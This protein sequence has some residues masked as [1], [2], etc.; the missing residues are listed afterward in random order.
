[1]R[2]SIR[3][4]LAFVT[5]FA[6]SLATGIPGSHAVPDGLW[7]VVALH[8][9]ENGAMWHGV[10]TGTGEPLGGVGMDYV[11]TLRDGLRSKSVNLGDT[12]IIWD[13]QLPT[14]GGYVVLRESKTDTY[15]TLPVT[16]VNELPIYTVIR[17]VFSSLLMSVLVVFTAVVVHRWANRSGDGATFR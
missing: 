1:M 10:D 9:Q 11:I 12:N 13:H 3:H 6:L 16:V 4:L 2:F 8:E 15:G 14:V 5:L 7:R 17:S